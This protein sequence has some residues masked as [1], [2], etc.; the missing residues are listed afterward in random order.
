MDRTSKTQVCPL[1]IACFLGFSL[2]AKGQV[3]LISSDTLRIDSLRVE[4]IKIGYA[5][6]NQQTLSGAVDKVSEKRMNKGFVTTPLEALSGQ[7][8]GVSISSGE[9]RA[10]MLSSVRVRGTTSLTGGNDPLVII[11]GVSADLSALNTIYPA[12]IESFTI[13]K[14]ASET[15]QY[16]SR[17][18]SGVIEVATKKGKSESL[19]VRYTGNYGVQSVY[20]NLE[21]LSA[22]EFRAVAR[23]LNMDILDLGN[24]TNFPEEITRL[25]VMQ[26]HHI[27]FGG[28]TNTTNYRASI[29]MM[30]RKEVVQNNAYQ[31]FTAKVN[32]SQKA[33]Q[34]YAAKNLILVKLDFPRKSAQSPAEKQQ[35]E[36]LAAKYKVRGYP[37]VLLM[38]G[39]G[40]VIGKTGYRRGG[41]E[42]Y[43]RHLKDLLK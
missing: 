2:G 23:Q 16:G 5:V 18:A 38:D 21:M 15:A 43:V 12:D 28:G 4:E 35:N 32:L 27:A 30:D 6:G 25:G 14:D 33:F 3:E 8:A 42:S 10:A 19:R 1:L 41:A 31:N 34:D 11:D 36:A 40:K 20:K 13:L 9:N 22:D 17:G 37:T 29:G 24:Q 26:N 7:S 39:N